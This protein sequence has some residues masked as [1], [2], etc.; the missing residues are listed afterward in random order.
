MFTDLSKRPFT[1]GSNYRKIWNHDKGESPLMTI[2][3]QQVEKLRAA[4]AT[5]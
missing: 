2:T 4:V 5:R 1:S 3:R